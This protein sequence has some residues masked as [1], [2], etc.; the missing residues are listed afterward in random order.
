MTTAAWLSLLLEHFDRVPSIIRRRL[1]VLERAIEIHLGQRVV[2]I[3]FE[4]TREKDFC[5]LEIT[6]AKFSDR[7]LVDVEPFQKLRIDIVRARTDEGEGIDRFGFSFHL[8][9]RD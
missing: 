1:L 2:G 3:E 5:L 4:E 8:D 9:T 7:I 6:F